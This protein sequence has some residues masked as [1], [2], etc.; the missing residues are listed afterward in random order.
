MDHLVDYK[1]AS[2]APAVLRASTYF[3]LASALVSGIIPTIVMFV[4]PPDPILFGVGLGLILLLTAL[5]IWAAFRLLRGEHWARFVLSIVAILS[6]TG[7]FSAALNPL[8]ATGL[9][10]TLA[11]TVLMWLPASRTHVRRISTVL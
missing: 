9:V 5:Q 4:R 1:T 11:G 2:N 3:W 7:A 10:L 6:L 8:V